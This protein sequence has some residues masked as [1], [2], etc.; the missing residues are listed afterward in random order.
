MIG[1]QM[2]AP[3]LCRQKYS[4]ILSSKESPAHGEIASG[5]FL[6]TPCLEKVKGIPIPLRFSLHFGTIRTGI[7]IR[8][9]ETIMSSLG[10]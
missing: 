1:Q 9:L 4:V 5:S 6:M 8:R 2:T 7:I 10:W 3:L